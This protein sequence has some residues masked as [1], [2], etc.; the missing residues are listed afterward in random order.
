MDIQQLV[1]EISNL[2]ATNKDLRAMCITVEE[3]LHAKSE[4]LVNVQKG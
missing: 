2:D 3:E 4:E 1:V